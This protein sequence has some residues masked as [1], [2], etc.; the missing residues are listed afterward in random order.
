[1]KYEVLKKVIAS[2]IW[3]FL[4]NASDG[5]TSVLFSIISPEEG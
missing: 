2:E 1:M 4:N 5:F 3:P